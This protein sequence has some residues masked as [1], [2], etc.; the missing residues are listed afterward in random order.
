LAAAN[1]RT[2]EARYRVAM[3]GPVPGLVTGSSGLQVLAEYG[4]ADLEDDIDTLLVAGGNGAR[5]VSQDPLLIATLQR[6]APKVRRIGSVCS[7]AFALAA[8]G[9]LDGKRATTHWARAMQLRAQYPK[10]LVEEDAIFCRDGKTVTSAG[11]TAGL[12]LALGLLEEDAG[13]E[14]AMQVARYFVMYLRRPG[15]QSQ[16][17]A[18]LQAQMAGEGPM[19]KLALWILQNLELPLG[20]PVLADQ[21]HMSPRHFQRRFTQELGISPAAFV[22]AARLDR[23]RHLLEGSD[24][25]IDVV[26]RRSGF[27]STERMRRALTRRLGA[28]PRLY[29]ARFSL[30]SVSQAEVSP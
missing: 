11:V 18:Q 15:G 1:D 29:R 14:V 2:G 19:S 8:A 28:T 27:S 17:S 13:F 30:S 5:L 20:V 4:W 21:V 10:V 24:I 3:A 25:S 22:E 23:A 12:D 16:F 7:G 9:L 26:A 6:L